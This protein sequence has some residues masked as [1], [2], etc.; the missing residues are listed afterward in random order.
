MNKRKEQSLPREKYSIGTQAIHRALSIL[1]C[2]DFAHPAWGA[3][4]LSEKLGLTISTTQ[5]ILR[6]LESKRLL[7]VNL[8]TGEFELGLRVF[9]L[10]AVVSSRIALVNQAKE[11]LVWLRDETKETVQLVIVD[12]DE[13]LYVRNIESTDAFRILSPVGLRRPLAT[14]SLGKAILSTYPRA[15]LDRYFSNHS[16]VQYTQRSIT[17]R[18]LYLEDLARVQEQGFATDREE[19]FN[20]V[21]ALAAPITRREGLAVGGIATVYPVLHFDEGKVMEQGQLVRQ[22]GRAISGRLLHAEGIF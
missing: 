9:E 11:I 17:D 10:G 22:A 7:A 12:G 1:A 8:K 4:G 18:A 21:C 19:V 6:A 16:L 2:F 13:M 20:G 3:R 5:R 14:G 15:M